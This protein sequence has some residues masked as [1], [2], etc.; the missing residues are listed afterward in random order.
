MSEEEHLGMSDSKNWVSEHQSILESC[1][2]K[3]H[4]PVVWKNLSIILWV[5]ALNHSLWYGSVFDLV[6]YIN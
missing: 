2:Q 3:V 6:F 4:Q 5:D 1:A